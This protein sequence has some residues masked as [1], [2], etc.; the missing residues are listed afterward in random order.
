MK[1]YS[2]VFERVEKKYLVTREERFSILNLQIK[3]NTSE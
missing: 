2:E 3:C 1:P